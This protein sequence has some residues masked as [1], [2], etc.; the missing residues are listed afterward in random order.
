MLPTNA[1]A[2]LNLFKIALAFGSEKLEQISP[3]M[4]LDYKRM[5]DFSIIGATSYIL[6]VE[7]KIRGYPRPG[8]GLCRFDSQTTRGCAPTRNFTLN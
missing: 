1:M 2:P 4:H 3:R 5:L 6:T 8:A 7:T